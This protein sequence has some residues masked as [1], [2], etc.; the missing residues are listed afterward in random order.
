MLSRSAYLELLAI[1]RVHARNA[2]EAEDLLHEAIVAALRAGREVSAQERGWFFGTMRNLSAMANRSAARRRSREE[3]AALPSGHL[4][5]TGDLAPLARAA[6]LPPSLRIVALLA[7][8]GHNRAEIRHLLRIS[9]DALRQRIA[10]IRRVWSARGDPCP[11]EFPALA[12][13]LAFGSIRRSLLPLM[14]KGAVDFA[15]HDPDAHPIGFRIPR[16]VPHE[17]RTGGNNGSDQATRSASCC[18]NPASEPSVS[19]S[20]TSTARSASTAT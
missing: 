19:T 14:R 4:T 1:A 18:P 10:A 17:I 15:S 7:L 5:D 16:P 12:G 8:A 3:R 2:V 13:T 11:V 20:P 6:E 9:D